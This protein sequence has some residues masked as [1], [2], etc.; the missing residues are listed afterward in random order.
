MYTLLVLKFL[1]A[2]KSHLELKE[3]NLQIQET[4]NMIRTILEVQPRLASGGIGKTSDE[5]VFELS[6]SILGKLP[7]KLDMEQAHK[8]LLVVR[9]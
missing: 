1:S 2:Q 3:I 5:I 4:Q 7:D 6:E 9:I 8:T